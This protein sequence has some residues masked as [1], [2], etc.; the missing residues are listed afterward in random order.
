[1][2]AGDFGLLFLVQQIIPAT[3]EQPWVGCTVDPALRHAL[4]RHFL[5]SIEWK[6]PATAHLGLLPAQGRARP[7]PCGDGRPYLAVPSRSDCEADHRPS[8][9]RFADGSSSAETGN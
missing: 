7:R 8:I 9:F 4:E 1:M 5:H 6:P 3:T 2:M